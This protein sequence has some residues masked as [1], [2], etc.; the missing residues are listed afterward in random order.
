METI[1]IPQASNLLHQSEGKITFDVEL[2]APW[3]ELILLGKMTADISR[4]HHIIAA[5]S[6][7]RI[8]EELQKIRL[9]AVGGCL[10]IWSQ[11]HRVEEEGTMEFS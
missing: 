5:R 8:S 7:Y 1:S 6:N 4:T 2:P 3:N 10:W 9:N 11:R